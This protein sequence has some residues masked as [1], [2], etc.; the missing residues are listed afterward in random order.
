M[1]YTIRLFMPDGTEIVPAE[2]QVIALGK[3]LHSHSWRVSHRTFAQL[4]QEV[5]P[6]LI[7]GET[8]S[9]HLFMSEAKAKRETRNEYRAC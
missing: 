8:R 7:N 5:N 2:Q 4:V 9:N 6:F 3:R 1:T